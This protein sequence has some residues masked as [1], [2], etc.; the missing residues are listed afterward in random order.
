MLNRRTLPLSALRAFEATGRHLHM[1]RAGEELGVT[2]GAISHQI[3]ALEQQ[4]G[5]KLFVRANSRLQLTDPGRRLLG[6]VQAAFDCILDGVQHLDLGSLSGR[7]VIGC[8]QTAGAS[9]VANYASEFHQQYPQ[10]EI[11]LQEIKPRQRE[12]SR[13][14][15]IAICYGKPNSDG[16]R[17]EELIRPHIFPVCSPRLLHGKTT[18]TRP[19]HL[20]RFPLLNDSQNSWDRWFSMMHVPA[21]THLQQMY[22]FNTNLV[23]NVARQGHG[24][25]LCNH[26]EIREDLR[27]GR[28][29]QLLDR[30]VPES[31]S[32]YL[33][34]EQV[35]GQS[36]RAQ[37][38]EMWIKNKLE[39]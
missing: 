7:L 39:E 20:I 3:R 21:P 17:C 19:E 32:Y 26:L 10:M 37:L 5:L 30:P 4:L 33:L 22:F 28:L 16:R 38:F 8:T 35:D 6:S 23:L 29:I 34:T 25:A 11:H 27:E 18:V 15:D 2:H 14:I 13:E 24:L 31:S 12:I 36:L 1:G 9:W